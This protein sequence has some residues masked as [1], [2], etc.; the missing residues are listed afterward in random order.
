MSSCEFFWLLTATQLF[1][2]PDFHGSETILSSPCPRPPPLPEW[3]HPVTSI[4]HLPISLK[5]NQYEGIIRPR[6]GSRVRQKVGYQN[7]FGTIDL[8]LCYQLM[9][10]GETEQTVN[11][12]SSTKR[13]GLR[14]VDQK[15]YDV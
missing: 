8:F 13:A 2:I 14:H 1:S 12:K 15:I 11:S 10:F 9:L 7:L 6:S 5:L 3:N 4:C